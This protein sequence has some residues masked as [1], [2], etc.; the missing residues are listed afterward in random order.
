[1]PLR[2]SPPNP[3]N[4][5]T[6]S[7]P[8]AVPDMVTQ[9]ALVKPSRPSGLQQWWVVQQVRW[10]NVLG[11]PEKT[12]AVYAHAMQRWPQWG[13]AV[14]GLAFC[15]AARGRTEQAVALLSDLVAQDAN[16]ANAWFNLGF[17]LQQHPATQRSA[18]GVHAD[19]AL[20]RATELDPQL[21]RAWY[22]LAL[23]LIAQGQHREAV[24]C[25]KACTKIQPMSPYAWYQLGRTYHTLGK[26]DK[27]R[28]VLV[29]LKTFDPKI[30]GQ[31]QREI[32]SLAVAPTP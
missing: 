3:M 23:E 15:H 30:S 28:E 9:R 16:R 4:H 10:W 32:E 19:A 5:S 31:L 8:V 2:A 29:H 17:L 1:V 6:T 24:A 7:Q 20:R 11:Q 18:Q 21:D 22:G 13:D 26:A 12:A 25:L 14:E 27:A